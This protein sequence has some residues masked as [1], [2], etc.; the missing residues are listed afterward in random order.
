[1]TDERKNDFVEEFDYEKIMAEMRGEKN[2]APSLENSGDFSGEKDIK[3]YIPDASEP[4]APE[5]LD[6]ATKMFKKIEADK[7]AHT[8]G[9]DTEKQKK[10]KKKNKPKKK[11]SKKARMV[12]TL[13]WVF[14]LLLISVLL[15]F[16]IILVARDVYGFAKVGPG[17]DE[18]IAIYIEKGTS[19]KEVAEILEDYEVVQSSTLFRIYIKFSGAAPNFQYGLHTFKTNYGYSDIVSTL[20]EPAEAENVLTLR[21]KE[22][23]NIDGI[24]ALLEKNEVCTASEFIDAVENGSYTGIILSEQPENADIHYVLE[25][26]LFPDTYEFYKNEKPENVVQKLIDNMDAKYDASLR[27]ATKNMGWTYHQVLT[28][29]SIVELEASGYEDQKAKVAAV[30]ENRLNN[31]SGETAG[32]LGSTPTSKYPYGDGKYDTNKSQ[33]LPPGPL[34]S[35][36]LTSIQAVINAEADFGEYYYFVTDINHEFYYTKTLSEHEAMI[37]KLKRKGLWEY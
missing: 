1:M 25:G 9:K 3:T 11:L 17:D 21:I 12:S 34:C 27:E 19:V 30:F 18:A 4:D 10:D 32:Y 8:D 29:A 24:A 35:P 7:P 28:L 13:V 5:T 33:G 6:G 15:A 14:G 20:Q 36:S 23:M 2:A 31:P 16:F 37:A 22:G 26:Y